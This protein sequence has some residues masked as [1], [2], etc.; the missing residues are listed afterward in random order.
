MKIRSMVLAL[1]AVFGLGVGAGSVFSQDEGG[2]GGGPDEAMMKAW[3]EYMTPG[4]EH[5]QM[6]AEAGT[7]TVASKMWMGGPDAPAEESTASATFKMVLGGRYQMQEFSGATSGMPFEGLALVGFDNATKEFTSV[8]VDS[9]GTGTFVSKGKRGEDGVITLTGDMVD[10][11]GNA[12]KTRT[13]LTK[14]GADSFFMEMFV[15][16]PMAPDQEAKMME[17]S[18]TRQK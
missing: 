18:Y 16:H 3:Q 14:K 4:K 15:T 9:M 7:W 6:A 5:E 1:A 11:T 12:M 13:L 2:A 17:L 8:W 10:P